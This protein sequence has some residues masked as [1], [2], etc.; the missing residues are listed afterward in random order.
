MLITAAPHTRGSTLARTPPASSSPGCPAHAGIDPSRLSTARSPSR[1]PR[2]RGDRP[3]A[4]TLTSA[5]MLAAPHTRGSTQTVSMRWRRRDG[6][7]A[8]AGIDP[9]L[10]SAGDRFSRLPR[11]RGDRPSRAPSGATLFG[12][13]PHTRGSTHHAIT[14]DARTAGCPAH[15]GIDPQPGFDRDSFRRLP[16]TRGDRPAR[17]SSTRASGRAAPHTRGSTLLKRR[18]EVGEY[19]CPAHAGIDPPPRSRRSHVWRLPRTRGDRPRSAERERARCA[20]APHTR[21]STRGRSHSRPASVGCPAHAGIDP[22]TRHRSTSSRGLPRTRG[23]R[24]TTLEEAIAALWAAPHTRGST[25][26]LQEPRARQGGCPAHAG[27]DPST[28]R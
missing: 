8:H 7:P 6:C 20:A 14:L 5:L 23:D 10:R 1:L 4:R 17:G 21:G 28:A 19:G 25:L 18:A 9:D 2:T 12:A 13:A 26:A 3:T 24:P 16:R 15:A 11:T 22:P 27:I